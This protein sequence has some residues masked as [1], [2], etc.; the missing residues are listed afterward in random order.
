MSREMKAFTL[1]FEGDIRQFAK[2]P[3]TTETP[4]GV[5]YAVAAFDAL[6][7]LDEALDEPA[8][9]HKSDCAIYNGPAKN[10]GPCD[11]G[12]ESKPE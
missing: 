11:C 12:A 9:T 4:F 1:V 2:N 10:P 7:R 8:V 3:L 5:P 6:E